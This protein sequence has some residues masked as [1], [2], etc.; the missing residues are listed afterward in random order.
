MA[1]HRKGSKSRKKSSS[2]ASYFG[3]AVAATWR[4][5]AKAVGAS[6]R[7]VFRGAKDLDPAHQRDGFAFLIF[8]LAL[9]SA[10]GVWFHLNNLVGR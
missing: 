8:I 9:I 6:I 5:F 2:G 1:T 7:F 3:R 4:F 10:A